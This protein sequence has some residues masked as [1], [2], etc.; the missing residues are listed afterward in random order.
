MRV[1]TIV[2]L[3][4]IALV[5]HAQESSGTYS[6]YGDVDAKHFRSS[7]SFE[8][9]RVLAFDDFNIPP[10]ATRVLASGR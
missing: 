7:V 5:A 6:A 1:F 2:A 10:A 9:I 8:K 3:S 4:F